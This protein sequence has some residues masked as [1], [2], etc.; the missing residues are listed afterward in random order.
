MPRY[1]KKGALGRMI[2][3]EGGSSDPELAEVRLTDAEYR[4]LWN[5]IRSYK[6]EAESALAE[7]EKQKNEAWRQANRAVERARNEADAEA[8]R[9]IAIA[10]QS[11]A[12]SAEETSAL[13]GRLERAEA[14]LK[15]AEDLHANLIRIMRERANQARGIKPKKDHDGYVV[16][17]SRQWTERYAEDIWDT[18]EHKKQYNNDD[19][20]KLAIENGY[21]RIDRKIADVWKSVMQTPY[22]ASLPIEQ[23]QGQIESEIGAV[24]ADIGVENRLKAEY[25]G[26]YYD[27]GAHDDGRKK[28]GMYRWTYRANYRSG[29]W[30]LELFTTGSLLV[31]EHRRPPQRTRG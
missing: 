4:D 3:A 27:F 17:E 1:Y 5:Q 14:D 13:R 10:H 7:G 15:K 24:L 25:N 31:P 28:N 8:K 6:R 11:A 29:L 30:E 12:E 9:Q 16:L 26:T 22:N 18:D 19:N 20:R 23:I 2:E 21:L